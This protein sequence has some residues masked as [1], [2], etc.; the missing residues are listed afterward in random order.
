MSSFQQRARHPFF[1]DNAAVDLRHTARIL[2]K[3][4]VA[5]HKKLEAMPSGG[6]MPASLV[7]AAHL[8]NVYAMLAG[9]AL[10]NLVRGLIIKTDP[11]L[12]GPDKFDAK[13]TGGAH[14][15]DHLFKMAK[16]SVSKEEAAFLETCSDCVLWAGRYPV[17]KKRHAGKERLEFH[18]TFPKVFETLFTRVEAQLNSK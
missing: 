11:T 3:E 13:L 6:T 2:H 8:W 1:W 14:K 9:L 15:L 16:V 17:P 10:E 12:V 7:P 5:D 4:I 18:G